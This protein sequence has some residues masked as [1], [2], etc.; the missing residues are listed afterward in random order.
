M[1]SLIILF[2]Y[3]RFSGRKT[4]LKNPRVMLKKINGE[5]QNEKRNENI[6]GRKVHLSVD[7]L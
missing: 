1:Y 3:N 2:I 4:T 5:K 6:Q 7:G